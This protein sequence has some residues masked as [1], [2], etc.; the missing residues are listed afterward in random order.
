MAKCPSYSPK[1]GSTF[2]DKGS[3]ASFPLPPGALTG[4]MHITRTEM[5]QVMLKHWGVERVQGRVVAVDLKKKIVRTEDEEYQVANQIIDCSGPSM[6]LSNLLKQTKILW[7]VCTTWAYWDIV[8]NEPKK[9]F[10]AIRKRK[11]S[12]LR[13][14]YRRVIP[15]E[16]RGW[17]PGQSTILTKIK[18]GMWTWQIPLYNQKLLSYGVVYR[19]QPVS[20]QEYLDITAKHISPNYTLKMRPLDESGIYNRMYVRN[21]FARSAAVPATMDYIMVSDAFCFADPIYS[22]GSGLAINKAIEVATVL[23]ETGWSPEICKGYCEHYAHQLKGA[24]AGFQFWY[25]GK[26][27]KDDAAAATVQDELLVGNAFQ[28]SITY[29]YVHAAVSSDLSPRLYPADRFAVDWGD[30]KLEQASKTLTRAVRALIGVREGAKVEGWTFFKARPAM[31]GVL[32][33][34][35][36]G[37]KRP[38]LRLLVSKAGGKTPAFR[39]VGPLAVS[40]FLAEMSDSPKVVHGQAAGLVDQLAPRLS[41]YAEEWGVLVDKVTQN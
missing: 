8:G 40:Y 15:T 19:G 26:T 34:W 21:N 24:V 14:D 33:A 6:C 4:A 38:T 18:D 30:P 41:E 35:K 36:G 20:S 39:T 12:W 22:V 23:N 29:H 37:A 7:P 10:D 25:D 3:V 5:E 31:D 9:F 28:S 27:I 11:W 1:R 17:K 32:L 2:I 16:D 13:Y